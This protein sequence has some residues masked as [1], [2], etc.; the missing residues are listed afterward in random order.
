MFLARA[1]SV[2]GVKK[3]K[4][5]FNISNMSN[6]QAYKKSLQIANSFNK[7][8]ESYGNLHLSSNKILLFLVSEKT[9]VKVRA[10]LLVVRMYVYMDL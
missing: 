4:T 9:C 2:Q 1:T 7:S 3:K 8:L 6:D 5:I 10:R